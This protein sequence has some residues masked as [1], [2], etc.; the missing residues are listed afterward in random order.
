[1][2]DGR[3]GGKTTDKR[4][5]NGPKRLIFQPERALLSQHG[6]F[7]PVLPAWTLLPNQQF[8]ENC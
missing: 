2:G 7:I 5:K 3:T 6:G 1:M 8:K 4:P